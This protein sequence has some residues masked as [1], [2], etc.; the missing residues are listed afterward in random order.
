MGFD[1]G[2][3]ICR[4]SPYKKYGWHGIDRPSDFD[5]TAYSPETREFLDEVSRVYGQFSA[6]RLELT[7]HVEPPWINTPRD[8]E[9]TLASLNAFF[10]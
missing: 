5:I 8:A 1:R 2:E 4:R 10:V 7:T 3:E 9:I 6:K